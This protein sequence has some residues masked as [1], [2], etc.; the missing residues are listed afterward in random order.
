MTGRP[1]MP[2]YV[3]DYIADT[4]HLTTEEHGAYLLLMM[5]Y[6]SNRKLPTD[7]TK[8]ARI[9]KLPPRRW[10]KSRETL[11][12]FFDANLRHKRIEF[13]ITQ[14]ERIS[15]A[16]RVGG[17]ASAAVR[18]E[19][20]LKN[21][22]N[23]SAKSFEALQSQS[24]TQRKIDSLEARKR[25]CRLDDNW[26]PSSEDLTYAEGKGL[27]GAEISVEAE[28]FRNHWTS[29]GGKDAA[30]TNWHR[31][32]E[33]WVLTAIERKGRS[34]GAYRHPETLEDR[35]KRLAAEART[36][37]RA[38]GIGRPDDTFGSY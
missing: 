18:R 1:W 30:K 6:W 28:K 3:G 27:S 31:T 35:G 11:L 20:S 15:A 19:R 21:R 23:D 33:N 7:E 14:A 24:H 22:S 32:W 37:E 4:A 17:L 8:L 9:C 26:W 5:H 29:K 12:A 2:L 16:G 13:E 10:A 25:A 38:A 34:N 36:L